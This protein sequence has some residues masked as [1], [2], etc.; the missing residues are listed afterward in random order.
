MTPGWYRHEPI[1]TL[2]YGLILCTEEFAA[3]TPAMEVIRARVMGFCFGVRDA[4]AAAL[5]TDDAHDVTIHG[6][7]VHNEVV[8]AQLA[9]RGFA[10][11]GETDRRTT[12]PATSRVLITAHG[13]SDRERARLARAGKA[14]IDTTCPLVRK[15]HAAAV[16]LAAQGRHVLVLGKHGHV[17]V[18]GLVEDLPSH[19]VVA[20]RDDVRA[21]GHA[22]LGVV[23]QTT[24]PPETA[25]ELLAAIAA[26]NPA[27]DIRTVD[28]ICEPT[29][30]R[31]AAVREL[32]PQVDAMVVV[33]GKTSNNTH[34]L[35]QLCR[36]GGVPT[37]LVQ[38]PDDLAPDC[39]AH[40][41]RVGLTAGT[42]T[43]DAVI[44]AVVA[45]L[46]ALPFS[47]AGGRS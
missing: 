12:L 7:L 44:D 11:V 1:T 15:A 41:R 23:C 22:H 42:S 45:A 17:E 6:E 32:L 30:Q 38:G 18:R 13:V 5:A 26:A 4:L 20:S 34:K 28:T 35:A 9:A 36:D 3:T 29:K 37:L 47:M 43:P 40:A 14:L 27:A 24:L 33:G 31:L 8:Q 21:Y 25:R 19:D 39:F 46:R 16:A 2:R 10:A